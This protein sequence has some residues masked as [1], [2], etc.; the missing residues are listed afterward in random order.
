MKKNRPSMKQDWHPD[1]KMPSPE[2]DGAAPGPVPT[3]SMDRSDM[4]QITY[5]PTGATS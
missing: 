2:F 5:D 4:K 3:S 1:H